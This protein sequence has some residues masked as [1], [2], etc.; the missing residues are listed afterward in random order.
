MR[1]F[2]ALAYGTYRLLEAVD[3]PAPSALRR[4]R[5]RGIALIVALV[6]ITVL[7]AAVVEYAYTTRVNLTMSVN[8]KDRVKSYFLARSG[9]NLSR[10]M[11]NFQYALQNESDEAQNNDNV[12][13]GSCN[14]GMI[15]VAMRRSNFQMHQY[16]DLLMR[17][18]NNGKLETP[19]G[20]INL[21]EAGVDG[22]GNFSGEFDLDISP[23]SG[24]LNVNRFAKRQV[25][26]DD[27]SELCTMV[28]DSQYTEIFREDDQQDQVLDQ[29]RIL[30]Y[31]VDYIDLDESQLSL[32]DQCTLEGQAS[33]DEDGDYQDFDRNIEP[34]NAKLTHLAELYQVYGVTDAFMEAFGDKLTVYPVGKPNA[35]SAEMPVFYSILCRN[36]RLAD[37]SSLSPSGEGISLCHQ[38]PQV[39]LQ[40]LY[41]ALALDGVRNFFRDPLSVLM[42]Y[43]GT[44]ESR[45]L[46]SAKKG[47]PVA[48]LQS[49]QVADYLKDF[50]QNPMLMARFIG[51]S[52]AYRQIVTRMQRQG[53]SQMGDFAINPRNPSFPEW[54]IGF[55]RTGIIRAVSTN[56]PSIYRIR[57]TGKYG[58]NQTTVETV[59]D[60]NETIRRLP[61]GDSIEQQNS[62]SEQAKQLKEALNRRKETMPR[63]RV[64]YWRE[65]VKKPVEEDDQPTSEFGSS[66]RPGSDNPSQFGDDSSFG[67]GQNSGSFGEQGGG[68]FGEQGGGGFGGQNSGGGFGD[69]GG[70]S[71]SSG[72]G[73]D[74]GFG[75]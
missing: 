17:P 68:G 28:A 50:K 10:L 26:Q 18:F 34:R 42:A 23:E 20:G 27:L 6:T 57:A 72:G 53:G 19:V 35:N 63:G 58:S 75:E 12:S 46:P 25:N 41:F 2:D 32:T 55:D 47:Q 45:L 61:S 65:N 40:V 60:F 51:Y 4:R 1:L 48:F 37:E 52:P 59:V 21:S 9:I 29:Y 33:G 38:S 13:G 44:T 7:S 30:R 54:S 14:P 24:K 15:S 8:A 31:I 70:G 5:P 49:S 56:N 62:D 22:F 16:M 36:A 73:W 71:D 66:A 43:V 39:A 3:R 69:Q 74:F 11:L 64:L 67:S